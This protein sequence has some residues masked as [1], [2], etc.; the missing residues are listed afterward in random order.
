MAQIRSLAQ[1]KVSTEPERSQMVGSP[2]ATAEN[3]QCKIYKDMA[4]WRKRFNRG[5]FLTPGGAAGFGRGAVDGAFDAT[6]GGRS[7]FFVGSGVLHFA[8]VHRGES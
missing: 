7:V 6:L 5:L 1:G 8:A 2:T 3:W 4:S